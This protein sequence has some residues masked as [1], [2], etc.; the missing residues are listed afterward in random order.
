MNRRTPKKETQTAKQKKAAMN[1]RTPKGVRLVTAG[2]IRYSAASRHVP[3]AP[4]SLTEHG[5]SPMRKFVLP[6]LLVVL[7][8]P[9]VAAEVDRA[10]LR[11]AVYL[12]TFSVMAGVGFNSEDGLVLMGDTRDVPAEIAA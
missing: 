2:D 11:K 5:V 7:A 12:P 9:G 4:S 3:A 8:R 10:R 6:L 1:R